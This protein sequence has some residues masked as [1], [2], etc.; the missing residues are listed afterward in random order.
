MSLRDITKDLLL[1][2]ILEREGREYR[3]GHGSS[4]EQLNIQECPFCNGSDWKVYANR[5]S[6]LG[7]CFHGSC[8][9]TFNLFTFT[10]AM[11]GTSKHAAAKY[12]EKIALDLGWRPKKRN[13]TQTEVVDSEDWHLPESL[14]MPTADGQI[15]KYLKDR[16]IDAYTA[17]YFK[18]RYC[19]DAWFNYTKPDGERGGM[20][21]GERVL[22][23]VYDLDGSMVTFQGRDI[24]GN[25][26]R[27]YLFPPGLPGTGRFLYNGQNATGKKSIIAN[28]G[29]FDVIRTWVNIRDTPYQDMGVVGTFGIHLSKGQDGNDQKNKFLRLKQWGLREVI[30]FWDGEEV[31]FKKSLK[32]ASELMSIGLRV[33]VARPPEGKDPG[34]LSASET[35]AALDAAILLTPLTILRLQIG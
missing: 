17:E 14:P 23:P 29:G 6:G 3:L 13:E 25:S 26:D 4:G 15:L 2:D 7:N 1:E 10:N 33:K 8:G 11:I 22:I 24:T 5:D 31:A 9:E 20:Y 30:L 34:D 35:V 28:E 16:R 18:L 21:F 19:M 32:A 12:L 27:K